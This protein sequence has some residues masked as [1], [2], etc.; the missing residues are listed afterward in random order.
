MQNQ[1]V[2]P[3]PIISTVQRDLSGG[4]SAVP[5]AVASLV[6]AL[7][8]AAVFG[9]RLLS[10]QAKVRET[11][12]QQD[13]LVTQYN[14]LADIKERVANVSSLAT[15]LQVAY[16]AQ[17]PLADLINIVEST[18]FKPAQYDSVSIDKRGMVRIVGSVPTYRDFAKV[19]KAFKGSEEGITGVTDTV[20]ID[21]VSQSF[22]GGESDTGTVVTKFSIS[23]FLRPALFEKKVPDTA[24][25]TVPTEVT[26]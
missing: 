15:G 25:N 4:G 1:P 21:S 23:F 2:G 3:A 6:I 24:T 10:L 19:V 12:T 17:T 20:T 8:G 16:A 5:F 22:S 13:Q 7:L 9:Y 26:P 11:T 14:S 18:S